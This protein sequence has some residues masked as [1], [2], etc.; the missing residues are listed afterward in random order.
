MFIGSLSMSRVLKKKKK[1]S[2]KITVL[3]AFSTEFSEG[4]TT[5]PCSYG[6]MYCSL[7][8]EMLYSVLDPC[9]TTQ[10]HLFVC[11]RVSQMGADQSH[12][13]RS[14]LMRQ[15][16]NSLRSGRSIIGSRAIINVM[17]GWGG[18]LWTSCTMSSQ[19]TKCNRYSTFSSGT[20]DHAH[21]QKWL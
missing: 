19:W 9:K 17:G 13:R 14:P 4:Q 12:M 16:W 21:V 7:C 20:I 2:N 5:A 10:S 1:P 11:Y 18:H 3:S 8:T 15:G 6:R